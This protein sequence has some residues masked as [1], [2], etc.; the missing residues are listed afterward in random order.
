MKNIYL[1]I[2]LVLLLSFLLMPLL[3]VERKGGGHADRPGTSSTAQ[4]KSDA[5]SPVESF[6]VYLT[7]EQKTV[8]LSAE[9]YLI[10]VVVS[11]MSADSHIEAL[12]AQALA[13]YTYAYRKHLQNAAAGA[14][15][16]IT[17]D[18]SLDQG[19]LT[20]EKRAEKWGDQAAA[21][22][23]T[24]RQ[25]VAAVAGRLIV[26]QGEP[27]LAAYHAIS[28]GNTE[29]AQNV[30]GTDYPYLQSESSVG[31]LLA[32][33]YLSEVKVTPDTFHKALTALGIT[34]TGEAS[35][36]I[37][38][39]EKSVAGMVLSITLCGTKLTGAEVREA[40]SLRSA[41][42]DLKYQ[43]NQFVFSVMGYGH[44]VGMSQFGADYM[45]KQG[46]GYE[47]IIAAYYR[48]TEIVTLEK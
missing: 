22:E 11:E 16:D 28:P 47:D 25:A 5:L 8:T 32:P 27:I 15:Y 1:I 30:W 3:A 13:A 20:K 4:Q 17:T 38:A 40:F 39:S 12:K 14:K 45:A 48:D 19:Y 18:S 31:D 24:V 35:A 26:Y 44:G 9:E 46:S 6:Q 10:G 29:T 21:K 33:E 41:A 43:D 2:T 36:Y 42:F 37:G 34:P 7:E 23:E